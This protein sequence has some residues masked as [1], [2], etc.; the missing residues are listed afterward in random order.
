MKNNIGAVDRRGRTV[1]GTGPVA[2]E[3]V[4]LDNRSGLQTVGAVV[5]RLGIDA[6]ESR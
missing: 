6:P 5:T 2:V 1:I 4:T 3:S